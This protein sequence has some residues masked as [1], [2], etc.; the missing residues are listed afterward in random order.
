M[1][2]CDPRRNKWIA[3]AGDK[4]DRISAPKLAGLRRGN[5]L[6]PVHH[7]REEPRVRLKR[8]VRWYED[9]VREA[10]RTIHQRRAG[11]REY[12]ARVPRRALQERPA[13][14]AGFAS[15]AR[16]DLVAQLRWLFQGYDGLRV[17]G[18]LARGQLATQAQGFEIVGRWQE[19]PGRGL[20]RSVTLL[21]YGD[22]PWRFQ[23]KTKRWKYCGVGLPRA[24]RGQDRHG[25][26]HPAPLELA[27][28]VTKRIKTVGVGATISAIH[29]QANGFRR[30]YER[31][32]SEGTV[33]SNARHAVARQ[34]L[35]VRWGL[36]KNHRGFD[37]GLCEPEET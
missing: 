22:T 36:W 2:V 34:L 14:E 35:L 11:A 30:Y 28:P 1:G 25:R 33:G 27:G 16:V 7:T 21:A 37:A 6:R 18:C 20:I 17:Q 29:R 15:L 12:G 8:G 4:G 10:T 13:R 32:V 5:Y 26:A 9:R 19:V 24:T 23:K 3:S 31:R